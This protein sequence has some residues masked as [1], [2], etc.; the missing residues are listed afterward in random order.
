MIG[1]DGLDGPWRIPRSSKTPHWHLALELTMVTPLQ[2]LK[3]P[4]PPFGDVSHSTE[5]RCFSAKIVGPGGGKPR[6]P[7]LIFR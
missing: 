4:S 7:W 2:V 5:S 6:N 3:R 1:P